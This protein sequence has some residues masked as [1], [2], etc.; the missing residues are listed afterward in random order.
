MS[1]IP[2]TF[3]A[4]AAT[5]MSPTAPV[6]QDSF[7]A[8]QQQVQDSQTLIINHLPALTARLGVIEVQLASA[9]FESILHRC[10]TSSPPLR[11]ITPMAFPAMGASPPP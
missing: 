11:K 4:A 5:N 7:M 8:F 6:S 9:S 1:P 3:R 2:A 10:P